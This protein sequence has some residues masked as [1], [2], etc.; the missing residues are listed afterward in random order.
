M[1]RGMKK[2]DEQVSEQVVA[3][4]QKEKLLQDD[5]LKGLAEKLAAGKMKANDWKMLFKLDVVTKKPKEDGK[6]KT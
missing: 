6:S 5:S 4:F 1:A 3:A 2:P